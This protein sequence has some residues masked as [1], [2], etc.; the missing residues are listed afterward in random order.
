[1]KTALSA[2]RVFLR[3]L[4]AEDAAALCGYRGLAE[5]ARFQSWATFDLEDAVDLIKEQAGREPGVPG[6]WFQWAIIEKA[7]GRMVGDCGLHCLLD[8]AFQMEFGI[9]LDPKHQKRGY[10]TEALSVLIEFVF[11]TLGKHRISAVTDVGNVAAAS[12]FRR[13]GF[14][15]EAHFVEHKWYKGSWSSE[16]VFA[17]LRH[18][19]EERRG[20]RSPRDS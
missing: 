20:S 2:E 5:V 17:I 14:R 19:W 13:L 18:E 7:T 4:E 12:L 1:M 16:L 6:T 15:Q 10:A 9:T 3:R 11:G 8:D